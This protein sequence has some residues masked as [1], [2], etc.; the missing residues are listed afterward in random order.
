MRRPTSHIHH[1]YNGK[2]LRASVCVCILY[3]YRAACLVYNYTHAEGENKN[4]VRLYGKMFF[5]MT[6]L[7]RARMLLLLLLLRRDDAEM[8]ENA[9]NIIKLCTNLC[10]T[11]EHT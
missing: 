3:M 6:E 2:N 11:N 8:A 10:D 4:Y 7:S 1:K 9:L 5:R